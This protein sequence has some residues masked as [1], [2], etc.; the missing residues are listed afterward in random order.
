[1]PATPRPA[2]PAPRDLADLP[3][4]HRLDVFAGELGR[5]GDHESVHFDG[6]DF[7]DL[8][9]GG[10]TFLECA[11]SSVAVE[12]GRYRRARFTDVWTHQTRWVG[13]DLAETQWTDCESGAGLLAGVELY[14]ARL[15]RM[16]FHRCKFDSVNLRAAELRDVTFV[17][18]LLRDVDFG[19]ARL[20]GVVFPGTTL[21]RVRFDN[22]TVDRADLS[23]AAA[24][25]IASGLDALRGATI[26]VL[27]LMELAPALAE[28]NGLRVADA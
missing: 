9:G 6:D 5:E 19:G 16:V 22:V 18:C 2:T 10:T 14:G 24:L 1:M 15:R 21:E 20:K 26:S 13:A 11:L 25:G 23:G 12:G 4:A 28:L 8:D 3:Y 17:D 7:V 27:Q